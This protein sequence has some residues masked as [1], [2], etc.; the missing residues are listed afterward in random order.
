M[1]ARLSRLF[2]TQINTHT[3]KGALQFE[4]AQ[5]W[6]IARGEY[7]GV[8]LLVVKTEFDNRLGDLIHVT[9]RGPL[10]TRSGFELDGIPHLAFLDSAL[11]NSNLS[12]VGHVADIPDDWKEMYSDWL[13]DVEDED[14][15]LLSLP[16]GEILGH[17]MSRLPV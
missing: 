12:L 17:I 14:A 15:G 13:N 9:I 5:V 11:Q 3:D 2:A 7:A 6:Q 8:Q 16:A 4:P 10:Y 1:H